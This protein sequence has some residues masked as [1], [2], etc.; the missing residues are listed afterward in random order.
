VKPSGRLVTI[1]A[2]SEA[3]SDQR[4]KD[5]FFVVDPNQKQ[6]FEVA[7]LLDAGTLKAFVSAVRST[8][9]GSQHPQ[10]KRPCGKVV[11]AASG[12]STGSNAC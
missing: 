1:A 6:L 11:I 9:K 3:T 4:V 12:R 2:N 10:Q 5:A 7:G 8:G